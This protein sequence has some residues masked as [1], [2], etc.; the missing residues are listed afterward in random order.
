MCDSLLIPLDVHP[1]AIVL[2]TFFFLRLRVLLWT[3]VAATF[4]EKMRKSV[5]AARHEE[6]N[7]RDRELS[8][9]RKALEKSEAACSDLAGSLQRQEDE[10]HMM[11]VVVFL[12]V[13]FESVYLGVFPRTFS[14]YSAYLFDPVCPIALTKREQNGSEVKTIPRA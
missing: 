4:E 1:R 6:I 3:A 10:S 5:E 8:K 14:E 11:C 9:I 7:L 13:F 12:T 2:A